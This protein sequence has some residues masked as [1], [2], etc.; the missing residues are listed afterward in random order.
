MAL[1]DKKLGGVVSFGGGRMMKNDYNQSMTYDVRDG[2]PTDQKEMMAKIMI[3][4]VQKNDA[5]IFLKA[6][7]ILAK[8]CVF[9]DDDGGY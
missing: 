7:K 9:D 2:D 6:F 4:A 3:E 5:S 1:K 8:E